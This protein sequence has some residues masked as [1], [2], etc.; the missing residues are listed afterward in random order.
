MNYSKIS[1]RYSKALFLLSK[2][3]S[4]LDE[5]NNDMI[6]IQEVNKSSE[7]FRRLLESPTIQTSDK[8]KVLISIFQ[9]K[10]DG[11]T[12][13]I[14]NLVV[15]NKR[16][17]FISDIARNFIDLFRK[18]KNIKAATLTTAI[19]VNNKVKDEVI[20]LVKKIYNANVELT[21]VVDE[22]IIG[23]YVLRIDDK[24][25]DTSISNKLKEINRDLINT[26]FEYKI[27]G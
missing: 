1:I 12:M 16:E 7:E 18:E 13:N 23:G 25:L 21:T 5:I 2:E 9:K 15:K 27:L 19:E 22:E 24:Q 8:Q 26:S 3:K 6:L 11:L 14:L 10:V 20:T 4:L 17:N